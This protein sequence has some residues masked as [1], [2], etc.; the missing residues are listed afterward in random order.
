LR[1]SPGPYPK[2][3]DR[4]SEAIQAHLFADHQQPFRRAYKKQKQLPLDKENI[5]G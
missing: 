1:I 5:N 4:P 2:L 3:D